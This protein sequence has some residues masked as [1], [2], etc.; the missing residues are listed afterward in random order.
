VLADACGFLLLVL[1]LLL[2]PVLLLLLKE[3][4]VS[5]IQRRLPDTRIHF[6]Y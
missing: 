2:L 1:L 3:A 6:V 5:S 4:D